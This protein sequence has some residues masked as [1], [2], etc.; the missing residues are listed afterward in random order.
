MHRLFA[1]LERHGD[2]DGCTPEK[3]LNGITTNEKPMIT[4]Q[5]ITGLKLAMIQLCDAIEHSTAEES[6]ARA[7]S[8]YETLMTIENEW[9]EPIAEKDCPRC[10][11][12]VTMTAN[13]PQPEILDGMDGRESSPDFRTAPVVAKPVSARHEGQD[14]GGNMANGFKLLAGLLAVAITLSPCHLNAGEKPAAK[15]TKERITRA[16]SGWMQSGWQSVKW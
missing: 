2:L 16:I 9:V 6:A 4:K 1:W 14:H 3:L 13:P 5:T 10:G 8:I 11:A 15:W 12:G 7:A